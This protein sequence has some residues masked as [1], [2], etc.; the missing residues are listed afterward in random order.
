M[1]SLVTQL[2]TVG[3]PADSRA[4]SWLVMML[5]S[6]PGLCAASSAPHTRAVCCSEPPLGTFPLLAA[7]PFSGR[8]PAGHERRLRGARVNKGPLIPALCFPAPAWPPCSSGLS[9][10]PVAPQD[11]PGPTAVFSC[12]PSSKAEPHLADCGP[13]EWFS[14]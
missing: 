14:S 12:R 9:P 1:W 3:S 13:L 5:G 10:A 7:V 11:S 2:P 4:Q 6:V 8:P